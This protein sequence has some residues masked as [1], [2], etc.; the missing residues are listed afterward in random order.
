MFKVF[1]L[2][3]ALMHYVNALLFSPRIVFFPS[4]IIR[5]VLAYFTIK[6]DP[7]LLLIFFFH[8]VMLSGQFNKKLQ[9]PQPSLAASLA[10]PL[11]SPSRSLSP[12]MLIRLITMLYRNLGPHRKSHGENLVRSFG[13]HSKFNGDLP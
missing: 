10:L 12:F 8:Y 11:L 13:G 2:I 6:S 9:P 3:L 4:H 7:E 5:N 1:T